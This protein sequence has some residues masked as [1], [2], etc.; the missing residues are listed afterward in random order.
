M[1]VAWM[2][3]FD[4]AYTLAEPEDVHVDCTGTGA[5]PCA[6]VVAQAYLRLPADC[7]LADLAYRHSHSRSGELVWLE[8]DVVEPGLSSSGAL[9]SSTKVATCLAA[10]VYVDDG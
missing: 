3:F 2:T 9:R 8:D 7:K 10:A 5:D 6:A 1:R 4:L